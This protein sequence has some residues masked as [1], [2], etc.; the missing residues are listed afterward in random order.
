MRE[1][2][3]MDGPDEGTFSWCSLWPMLPPVLPLLGAAALLQFLAPAGMTPEAFAK[4]LLGGEGLA[5]RHLGGRLSYSAVVYIHLAVCAGAVFFFWEQIQG[6]GEAARRRVGIAVAVEA[7][8]V[9][10][11]LAALSRAGLAAYDLT[12]FNI[13]A[14][15]AKAAAGMDFLESA[16]WPGFSK[17]AAAVFVPTAFGVV[18]VIAAAGAASLAMRGPPG[19]SPERFRDRIQQLQ[20]SFLFLSAVLVSSTLAASLFFHLPA[21]M[22]AF[23]AKSAQKGALL[24][25][26]RGLTLF[27]G[28]V[29]TLTLLAVYVPPAL[30]L[31]ERM[32]AF[33]RE[34]DGKRTPS[35]YRSWLAEHK[36]AFSIKESL[37]N[38]FALLAPLIAGPVGSILQAL[39]K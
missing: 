21:E 38:V 12:Y 30:I 15:F 3:G 19:E 17:L 4:S 37:G 14:L 35:E 7:L 10:G 18:A 32:R 34:R 31:R 1:V 16:L 11:S 29:Y 6:A 13:R 28:A 33:A 5:A 25:Y 26:A 39:A 36:L 27:W 23:A 8:V 24:D 2:A 9:L 22:F 20:Q